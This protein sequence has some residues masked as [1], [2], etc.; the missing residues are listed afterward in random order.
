M[1]I[2]E[3]TYI[4]I[5]GLV[6]LERLAELIVSRRNANRSLALGGVEAGASHYPAMVLMH[7][8][9]LISC[10]AESLARHEPVPAVLS[11]TALAV[12]IA[13]QI[14]R[15]S[16]IR[17]LGDR[18]STRIIVRPGSAPVIDGPYLWIRH[19]NYVAVV[20]E[21]AALPMIRFAWI[22]AVVFSILNAIVLSIRIAAEERALGAEYGVTLGRLP[23][24]LPARFFRK[25]I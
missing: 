21:I 3:R 22:T 18:W 13:A 14:L 20:L 5:L 19:P 23:R 2:D 4:A 7:S 6:A 10:V 12:A 16:A 11:W 17:T 24:F 8:A 25:R 1:N 15:W 9:F